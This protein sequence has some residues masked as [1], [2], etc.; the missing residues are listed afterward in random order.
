MAEGRELRAELEAAQTRRKALEQELTRPFDPSLRQAREALELET[1]PLR[2]AAVKAGRTVE[3]LRSTVTS[4]ETSAANVVV[5]QRG[6]AARQ[7]VGL[8]TATL[9]M[10]ACVA[11]FVLMQELIDAPK[12]VA[13][14]LACVSGFLVGFVYRFRLK[15]D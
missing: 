1:R 6:A 13:L 10:A 2:I 8:L 14:G 11:A 7:D 5:K 12:E 15:V 3:S 4:L 9:A